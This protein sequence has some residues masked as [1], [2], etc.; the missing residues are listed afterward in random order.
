MRLTYFSDYSLRILLYLGVYDD[1]L[2]PAGEIAEAYG[3]SQNHL[4]KVAGTLSQLGV[5]EAVRGRGGGFRLAVP[6]QE[7]NVGWLVRH[8]EPDF[9]LVECFDRENDTCPITPAC[10]LKNVLHEAQTSFLE[11][12]DRYTLADFLASPNRRR[13]FIKLWSQAAK[14]AEG[15]EGMGN[16]GPPSDD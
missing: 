13:A 9:H 11:T 15:V 8:T 12:L 3:V 16:G 6:P 4:L 7:V 5:V 10:M 1:R 2:V 14:S